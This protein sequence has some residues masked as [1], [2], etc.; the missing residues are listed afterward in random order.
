[1]CKQGLFKFKDMLG[2]LRSFAK[3]I[4]SIDQ[5]KLVKEVFNS[6]ILEAQI[7]DLNQDQLFN[8]GIQADGTPTGEYAYNTIFGTSKYAGKIQKG[9]R[10][11][12]ITGKDTGASYESMDVVA[13]ED[14]LVMQSKFPNSFLERLPDALGLTN[15]S[16]KQIRPEIKERYVELFKKKVRTGAL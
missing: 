3:K 6:P 11:D 15:E 5:N 16:F 4:G 2:K 12:H 7:I 13:K 10:Y 14:K 8:K 1:M 9:Q